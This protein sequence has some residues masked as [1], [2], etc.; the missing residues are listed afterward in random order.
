MEDAQVER[1]HSSDKR[2]EDGP[3]KQF[4]EQVRIRAQRRCVRNARGRAAVNGSGRATPGRGNDSGSVEAEI[5]LVAAAALAV[6]PPVA[7]VAIQDGRQAVEQ[8]T[9]SL[10]R[11]GIGRWPRAGVSRSKRSSRSKSRASFAVL[12]QRLAAS[13]NM[14]EPGSHQAKARPALPAPGGA[15]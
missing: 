8:T 1:E 12:A 3:G 11:F 2:E 13:T 9:Q 10:A 5:L 7:G 15:Y 14:D 6:V 4:D